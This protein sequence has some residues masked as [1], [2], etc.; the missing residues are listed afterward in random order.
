[1][2][3]MHCGICESGLLCK[4]D[5]NLL[6]IYPWLWKPVQNR[7]LNMD[8]ELKHDP[9]FLLISHI[10]VSWP[11]AI[12]Q[13]CRL[14]LAN[15]NDTRPVK[16]PHWLHMVTS[17]Q[18]FYNHHYSAVIMGLMASQISSFTI[19]C[20]TVCSG[21]DQRKHQSSASLAF[22]LGINRWPVNSPH[23]GPVT[24]KMFTFHDVIITIWMW[25]K[26]HLLSS[27]F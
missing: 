12:D 21:A 19:V 16:M 20:S 2:E 1:M 10:C 6:K 14:D 7:P 18:Q 22:L 25:W 5:H 9:R 26:F 4:N 3:Q 27:K 8:I 13:I 23:K 24:Q 17:Y 15:L 11:D